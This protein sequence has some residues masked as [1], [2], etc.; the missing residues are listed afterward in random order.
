MMLFRVGHSKE[1]MNFF[2]TS[3]CNITE[4]LRIFAENKFI[5][6]VG[7]T[8]Q[9]RVIV[10]KRD[11]ICIF[12]ACKICFNLHDCSVNYTHVHRV[13]EKGL[14]LCKLKNTHTAK[15]NENKP[16]KNLKFSF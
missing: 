7:I 16:V 2:Q 12:N 8:R 4:L 11:K 9:H 6:A 13:P 14:S 3:T 15:L 5:Y 1:N 10:S